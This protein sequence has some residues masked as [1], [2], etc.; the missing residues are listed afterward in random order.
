M[1]TKFSPECG[2]GLCPQPATRMVVTPTAIGRRVEALCDQ[3]AARRV[4]LG[5]VLDN[6]SLDEPIPYTLVGRSSS[7]VGVVA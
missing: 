5:P 4:E 7:N 1:H 3:H 2:F 6:I